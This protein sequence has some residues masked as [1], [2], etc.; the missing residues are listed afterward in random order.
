[1][2]VV[3][4]RVKPSKL[5][6]T[7]MAAPASAARQVQQPNLRHLVHPHGAARQQLLQR[8]LTREG[9]T[10]FDHSR[11]ELPPR[12]SPTSPRP[13]RATRRLRHR[14]SRGLRRAG[15]GFLPL[16]LEHFHPS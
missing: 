12:A 13:P 1:M 8:L 16:C 9:L 6:P 2:A 15:V 7:I 4:L 3:T 10:R 14:H 5:P 11:T